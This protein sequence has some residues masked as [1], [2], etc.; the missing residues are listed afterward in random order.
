LAIGAAQLAVRTS[1]LLMQT[2]TGLAIVADERLAVPEGRRSAGS[3]M[4]GPR[5]LAHEAC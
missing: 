2:S 4:A 5:G 3:M 1:I